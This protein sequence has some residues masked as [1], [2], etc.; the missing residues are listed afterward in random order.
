MTY[1]C[2]TLVLPHGERQVLIC[3]SDTLPPIYPNMYFAG[4]FNQ[5]FRTKSV[6]AKRVANLLN[7]SNDLKID[8]I[9]RIKSGEGLLF[10]E[11][12]SLAYHLSL[13]KTN[14][15]EKVEYVVEANYSGRSRE[16]LS[17]LKYLMNKFSDTRRD[18]QSY[19]DKVTSNL[20]DLQH[21]LASNRGRGVTSLREGLSHSERLHLLSLA[22][23]NS[24]TNPFQLRVRQRN[25]LVIR[26]LLQTGI[27]VSELLALRCD[28]CISEFDIE[29]GMQHFLKVDENLYLAEDPRSTPPEVKTKTRIIPI[30]EG[31]ATM[32]DQYIK[33]GRRYRGREAKK[34]PAY[35]FLSSDKKPK[36]LS[37]SSVLY[38]FKRLEVVGNSIRKNLS[39]IFPHRLR[40]TFFEDVARVSNFN[41]GSESESES[42]SESVKFKKVMRYLGGWSSISE[43]YKH[44]SMKEIRFKAHLSLQKLHEETINY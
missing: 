24:S 23:E 29:Y 5:A 33:N 21:V 11:M 39:P 14:S 19:K 12:E 43:Q 20:N 26:L 40:Y 8:L 25:E 30:S 4:V 7:W 6:R 18:A 17:F 36:P 15:P 34:A 2:K 13:K 3:N 44:Y 32:V 9:E 42:E 35:L 31:L 1:F 28:C 41:S 37:Y 38:M 27:R 16:T 22:A 10:R